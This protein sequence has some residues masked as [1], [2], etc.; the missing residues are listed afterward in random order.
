MI[1]T[2][3]QSSKSFRAVKYNEDKVNEGVAR[4]LEA[5]NFPPYLFNGFGIGNNQSMIR[6]F[7]IDYSSRNQRVRNPQFHVAISCEG[8]TWTDQQLLDFSHQWL[9]EMGY[10]GQPTLIYFHQ[11][12]DNNHLHIVTSRV[13]Q[14]GK[15]ISDSMERVRSRKIIN[16]TLGENVRK[17]TSKFL[18]DALNYR[19]TSVNQFKAICEAAGYEC[20]TE[21]E[22]LYLK[23]EG[24]VQMNISLNAINSKIAK[25]GEED[26]KRR[27]QIYGI[28]KKYW[29]LSSNINELEKILREQH[30]IAL[31]FMGKPDSPYGY[32]VVDNHTKRVYNGSQ[33]M[34]IKDLL[35][36]M[37]PEE[38][39]SEIND[40]IKV[41]LDENPYMTTRELNKTLKM[42]FG[43]NL[44]GGVLYYKK[45]TYPLNEFTKSILKRNDRRQWLS[46][47]SIKTED[48]A[49]LL[50]RVVG[51]DKSAFTVNPNQERDLL[52]IKNELLTILNYSETRKE[53]FDSLKES[54]YSLKMMDGSCYLISFKDKMCVNLD[55]ELKI[56][57]AINLI[58]KQLDKSHEMTPKRNKKAFKRK[59]SRTSKLHTVRR[60]VAKVGRTVGTA[61]SRVPS[62]VSGAANLLGHFSGGS[63]GVAGGGGGKKKKRSIYDDDD[64]MQMTR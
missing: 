9:K 2:I 56:G 38:M 55:N 26:E 63:G 21:N 19:F 23:K 64:D 3:L 40:Y 50:S 16:K 39:M 51:V 29:N 6:K 54:G 35:N 22:T 33:I 46:E 52:I 31:K 20:Y 8:R 60:T 58:K 12:T 11:D 4:L 30:G 17:T 48:E 1:A 53:F 42:Y 34:K 25:F 10:E 28:M 5:S 27:R 57:P 15:K 36:F 41:R 32:F 47:F 44:K 49:E 37:P 43:A 14:D 7:F 45:N 24:M 62:V 18:T 59:K 13:G 61:V